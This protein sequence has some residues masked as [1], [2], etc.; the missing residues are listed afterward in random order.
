MNFRKVFIA[1]AAIALFASLASAQVSTVQTLTCAVSAAT[2]PSIR[3]EGAAELV[4]D[5]LIT[6]SGGPT[7]NGTT[8]NDLGFVKIVVDAGTPV[9]SRTVGTPTVVSSVTSTP[10]DAVLTVDEPGVAGVGAFGSQQVCAFPQSANCIVTTPAWVLV[11]STSATP[12]TFTGPNTIQGYVLSTK[13]NQVVFDRIP[14]LTLGGTTFQHIF[15]IANIRVAAGSSPIVTTVT[16]TAVATTNYAP[17]NL[18]LSNASATVA[19]PTQGLAAS[20]VAPGLSLCNSP[21]A[22][23]G[24]KG[25]PNLAILTFAEKFSTAYKSKSAEGG[26]GVTILTPADGGI[27]DSGT[28]LKA[29]FSGLD[30]SGKITYYAS[31]NNVADAKTVN[32]G[33]GIKAVMLAQGATTETTNTLAT[34]TANAWGVV[35]VVQ[36]TVADSKSTAPGTAEVVWETNA[37][38]AKNLD[39]LQFAI[40]AT[41]SSGANAPAASTSPKIQLGFAPTITSTV[42]DAANFWIPRFQAPPA[43]AAFAPVLPCQTTLLFPFVT[44][45]SGFETGMAISNTSLDPFGTTTSA[46][47]CALSFYGANQPS[48]AITTASVAAG[49]TYAATVSSLGMVNF[50]GYMIGT[51]NFKLAHG[52]AFVQGN[53]GASNS[54]AM[55]YLP[56]VLN[57]SDSRAQVLVGEGVAQ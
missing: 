48:A 28:R 37:P 13:P 56:L 6:C 12:E 8:S 47:T 1:L 27:A 46:G 2:S 3:S 4:G 50:Q 14:V 49:T 32:T 43:A 25:S 57:N 26:L 45:Q 33:S 24:S 5:T 20:F 19:T 40:Y 42:T 11:Q 15:R 22:L 23:D 9:V 35:P 54:T 36:I 55:G 18:A 31:L 44:N 39:T 29:V 17:L 10:V 7:Q 21:S 30:T 41:Y 53:P 52:F 16:S 34:S 38:D 51:C